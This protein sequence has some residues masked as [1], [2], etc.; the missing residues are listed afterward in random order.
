MTPAEVAEKAGTS[1]AYVWRVIRGKQNPNA[2]LMPY[3]NLLDP[4]SKDIY[5]KQ[6]QKG[7]ADHF[8]ALREMDELVA[9]HQQ[10][11]TEISIEIPT[12][13]PIAICNSAD[14]QI[15]QPGVDYK[16]L[17]KDIETWATTDG[18]YNAL[19][20]DIKENLIQPQK[21][22]SSHNQSPIVVQRATQV[23]AYKRLAPRNLYV[24]TGNHDYW[25]ALMVGEDWDAELAQRMKLVY[26]Q[27][28][29]RIYLKVGK[30]EYPILRMHKGKFNSTFNPTHACKQ[31]QR[32]HFPDARIVVIE[33]QHIGAVEQYRYNERE[34][35][36]IRTGTYC[37]YDDFALQN[38]F[39]GSH[40]CNPTV[41]LYPNE[42]RIVPFKSQAD[43]L[44]YLK[45][46]RA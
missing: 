43:A 45:A 32:L 5:F 9:Y 21:M 44:I 33:H 22:G 12:D 34:C 26:T 6:R 3:L 31:Y 39:F 11:P 1:P 2:R 37:V 38:G 7:L 4:K 46:V 19:G 27:H 35:V 29:A 13:K 30:R 36:A 41:V 24:S 20:G 10:T 25:S 42:D 28:A 16:Q 14:W 15:G 8:K 40:V 18:L 23:L 17:E